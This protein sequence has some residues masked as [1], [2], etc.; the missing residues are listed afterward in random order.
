MNDKNW[1]DVLTDGQILRD[2]FSLIVSFALGITYF[3]LFAT[4]YAM[5]LGLSIVLVGIPLLLFTFAC[6]RVTAAMDRQLMA[7]ILNLDAPQ[8]ENE[9]SMRGANVGERLGRYLGSGLT[10]RSLFY[11][12]LKLG[13]GTVGITFAFVILPFLALEVLILAPLTVDMRLI[14]VRLLHGVAIGLHKFEGL[15]LPTRKPKRT[16]RTSRL[17]LQE[18][19]PEYYD[20]EIIKYKRSS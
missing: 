7:A 8:L 11:L 1:L 2:W 13:T 4:L 18:E 20:G 16:A 3:S 19:E 6:T 10:W 9:P 12:L 14:T 15:L 17:E 5:S